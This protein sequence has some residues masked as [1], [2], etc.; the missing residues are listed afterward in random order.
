MLRQNI[1]NANGATK[2]VDP[3]LSDNYSSSAQRQGRASNLS[4]IFRI[5]SDSED[6]VVNVK[7]YA[8]IKKRGAR[9]AAK[10]A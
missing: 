10:A 3:S 4:E 1:V 6:S 2:L 8:Q 9:G 5:D 7:W